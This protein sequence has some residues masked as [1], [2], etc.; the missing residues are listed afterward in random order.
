MHVEVLDSWFVRVDGQRM[1]LHEF[2]YQSRLNGREWSKRK[3]SA[4]K[5]QLSWTYGAAPRAVVNDLITQLRLAGVKFIDL[6][7]Q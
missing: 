7:S 5:I 4:P 1:A 6:G 3:L 2:I